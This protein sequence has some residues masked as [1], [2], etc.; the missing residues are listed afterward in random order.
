[1]LPLKIVS[2]FFAFFGAIG[3]IP[4]SVGL[5]GVMGY[6]V[7]RRTK[8]IGIR[9]ALGADRNDV[10]RMIIGEGLALTFTG[11]V[12]G[13]TVAAGSISTLTTI[14]HLDLLSYGGASLV[15]LLAAVLACYFPA[16]K[17]S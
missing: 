3:L 6:S 2:D 13:A 10:L 1:M 4:A 5:L 7:A 17:A 8:E 15:P 14:R 12:I 9:M 16:P 11:I